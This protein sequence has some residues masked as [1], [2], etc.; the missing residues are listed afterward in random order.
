MHLHAQLGQGNTSILTL[1]PV[2]IL[3]NRLSE[4]RAGDEDLIDRH[5]GSGFDRFDN[6][7]NPCVQTEYQTC[8]FPVK[9]EVATRN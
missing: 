2:P 7:V 9:Y 3:P 6:G 8:V 4:L 5:T 1:R